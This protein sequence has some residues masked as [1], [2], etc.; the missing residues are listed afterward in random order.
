MTEQQRSH[1]NIHFKAIV[2]SDHCNSENC[3]PKWRSHCSTIILFIELLLQP[4]TS[5][6]IATLFGLKKNQDSPHSM[7]SSKNV[8]L[9]LSE[10]VH[11]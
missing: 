6:N 9:H 3:M 2:V 1:P 5:I 7:I 4:C 10:S 8:G 11:R